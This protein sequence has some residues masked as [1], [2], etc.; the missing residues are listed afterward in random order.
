MGR[1]TYSKRGREKDRDVRINWRRRGSQS[2]HG[3]MDSIQRVNC[4]GRPGVMAQR[5]RKIAGVFLPTIQIDPTVIYVRFD[6]NVIV[7]VILQITFVTL[8]LSEF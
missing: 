3:T 8:V 4:M 6:S 2:Q 5:V 7:I 1:L